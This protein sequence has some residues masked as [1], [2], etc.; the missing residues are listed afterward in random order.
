MR[1]KDFKKTSKEQGDRE[2]VL[3]MFPSPRAILQFKKLLEVVMFHVYR[4][5]RAL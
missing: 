1:E 3:K 2:Q 4:V 5:N